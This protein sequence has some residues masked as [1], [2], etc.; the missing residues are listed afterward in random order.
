MKTLAIAIGGA[1]GAGVRWYVITL[2][3]VGKAF[4]WP[5]FVINVLGCALL[6]IFVAE[7]WTHPKAQVLLRD[8]AGIGF[9]GGLTTF[10]T[11]AVEIAKF[12]RDGRY[13]LA[14]IYSVASIVCGLFAA[15]LTAYASHHYRALE[16]PLEEQP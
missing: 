7:E 9:C 15:F 12:G 16:L 1:T 6:G 8:F 2:S 14:A 4:P 10:S 3:P 13:Q 5:V 11:F